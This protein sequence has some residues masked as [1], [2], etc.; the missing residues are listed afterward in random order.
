MVGNKLFQAHEPRTLGVARIVTLLLL[1]GGLFT[2]GYF[3]LLRI[4]KPA[5]AYRETTETDAISVPSVVFFG[6]NSILTGARV[7]L[8]R[9]WPSATQQ[10]NDTQSLVVD[11]REINGKNNKT[12][13][14]VHPSA[15]ALFYP[16][17]ARVSSTVMASISVRLTLEAGPNAATT[18][19]T[20]NNT[21]A[22]FI[23]FGLLPTDRKL[24]EDTLAIFDMV[25]VLE[26]HLIQ[27]A[28]LGTNYV[29][30]LREHR[31]IMPEGQR[32]VDYDVGV[33]ALDATTTTTTQ[34]TL[35]PAHE[36]ASSNEDL[37][38]HL[39]G[40]AITFA[41]ILYT[42]LF[43]LARLRPWGVVQRYLLR[44]HMLARL[45]SGVTWVPVTEESMF[46]T[47]GKIGDDGSMREVK[48]AIQRS[49]SIDSAIGKDTRRHTAT[50]PQVVRMAQRQRAMSFGS[51]V[52][53]KSPRRHAYRLSDPDFDQPPPW[54]GGTPETPR[55]I[56]LMHRLEWI[57]GRWRETRTDH[58]THMA[59]LSDRLAELEA[60]Q[61]R[62]EIFY[63]DT[64]LFGGS[65]NET[66]S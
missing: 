14:W 65:K 57:E 1:T 56:A 54:T 45:P 35:Q 40:S 3:E 38:F 26:P 2:L 31:T 39:L 61:R 44:G 52:I 62:V 33:D 58:V 9:T 30:R 41:M 36:R 22:S 55:D 63:H 43:G 4:I 25:D 7:V 19:T 42:F 53:N 6:A 15:S 20:R 12:A 46:G 8:S 29:I 32:N 34:F 51:P 50:V 13:I 11:T 16:E 23:S 64:E 27:R 24:T 28:I 21:S 37:S 5:I 17:N 60:F 47:E 18:I 49:E 10:G 48:S 66:N 59:G